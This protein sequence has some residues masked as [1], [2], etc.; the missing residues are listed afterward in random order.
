VLDG[1]DVVLPTTGRSTL[2]R[3]L[4]S[5]RDQTRA[6]RR[7][8]VVDDSGA[9]AAGPLALRENEHLLSTSGGEG[10][11]ASRELGRLAGE[12]PL[13]A[14][15][16]DDDWWEPEKLESQS[17]A[18]AVARADISFT[19]VFFHGRDGGV[20]ILP[21]RVPPGSG[22]ALPSYLVERPRLRHG[23]GYIQSSSLMVRR[24]SIGD[25]PWRPLRKH[26]DWDL[27]MRAA[28]AGA[29]FHFDPR[30]LAH[31]QQGSAGSLS[32]TRD[33]RMSLDWLLEHRACLS[34]R[35]I[36]D[37]AAVEVLRSALAARDG[38]GV[39]AALSL[40]WRNPPHAAALVVGASGLVETLVAS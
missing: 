28:V 9:G 1:I 36:G 39:R 13:V 25:V 33:W 18:F 7:I 12:S 15:L 24:S 8:F 22:E 10:G 5:V 23:D 4:Q 40:L 17:D 32:T 34:R 35:A 11:G 38:R 19:R 14:Y 31:V 6:P 26:Q 16:D 20:R 29:R 2:E 21:R 3:A 27:L 30:P 37:F